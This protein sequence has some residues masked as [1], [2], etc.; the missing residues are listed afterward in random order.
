MEDDAYPLP[1]PEDIMSKVRWRRLLSLFDQIKSYYQRIVHPE[2][3]PLTAVVSHRGQEEFNVIQMGNKGAPAHQQRYMDKLLLDFIDWCSC[4]IDNI[5]VA[6]YTF[7]E[8]L[9]HLERLFARMEEAHLALN[10]KK[11]SIAFTRIQL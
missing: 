9:E 11:C 5:I 2:S 8:H 7:D 3:R 6:S 10:L 4:Y 1:R